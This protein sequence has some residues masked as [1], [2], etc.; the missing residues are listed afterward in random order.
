LL[1][2]LPTYFFTVF[3]MS[4]WGISNIDKFRRSFLWKGQDPENVRGGHCLVNW[5]KCTRPKTL[6]GLGIKDLEKFNRALRLRWLWHHWDEIER[7]WKHL[8]KIIDQVDM[9]LFFSSTV[10]NIGDEKIL[11]FRKLDD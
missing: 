9:Q 6:G 1:N 5:L 10:I 3:K 2:Q 8:L 7:P 4:K 11:P